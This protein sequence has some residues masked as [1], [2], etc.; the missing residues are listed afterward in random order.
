MQKILSL[1]VAGAALI[2]AG[3]TTAAMANDD[4]SV[5]EN[6]E[7]IVQNTETTGQSVIIHGVNTEV[8]DGEVIITGDAVRTTADGRVII[9]NGQAD[10]LPAGSRHMVFRGS[11]R[12]HAMRLA[13][14][15][16]ALEHLD[17]M[18]FE[19]DEI[20]SEEMENA[21]ER[22][23]IELENLHGQRMVVINGERREMTDAEREDVRRELEHAREEIRTS[24]PAAAGE[25]RAALRD[26]H[27]ELERAQRELA[28]A[29]GE[30][31]RVHVIARH[32]LDRAEPLSR[33]LREGG[34]RQ[35]RFVSEDGEE[36]VWIDGEELEG[37]ART[38]W[39]GRLESG[40]LAGGDGSEPRR[41]VIEIDRDES[42]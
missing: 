23:E 16:A 34:A 25:L 11:D 2:A 32:D 27:V 35:L 17:G 26:V 1:S 6:V 37:D 42:E 18:R 7:I 4:V 19:F 38:E 30:V 14:A 15:S 33:E 29:E 20:R 24:L 21:L 10:I 9:S 36:R 31:R 8:R 40:R 22:V 12:E 41:I 39:L 28:N 13:E 3:C 5:R